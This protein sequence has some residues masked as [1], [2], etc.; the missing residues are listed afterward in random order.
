MQ[1][2]SFVLRQ[3]KNI[4]TISLNVTLHRISLLNEQW[5]NLK[6]IKLK[7]Q[8]RSSDYIYIY[9]FDILGR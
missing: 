7:P 4:W 9:V 1:F 5:N 2:Q 8:T 6:E 3:I